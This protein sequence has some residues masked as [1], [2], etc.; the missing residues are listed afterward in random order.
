MKIAVKIL[1]RDVL[2]DSQG[3]AVEDNFKNHHFA[4]NSCRIGKYIVLDLPVGNKDEALNEAKKMTEFL[5][6]NPLIE[7]Y[8][9]EVL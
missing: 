9:L 6:I 1:P 5:L 2:L 4:L 3:R 7:S 8:E